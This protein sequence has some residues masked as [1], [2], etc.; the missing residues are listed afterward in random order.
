M[1]Y[2]FLSF[3][4]SLMS[5]LKLSSAGQFIYIVMVFHKRIFYHISA[6]ASTSIINH[7]SFSHKNN[8]C[9]SYL[10]Y[11]S[12]SHKNHTCTSYL[13]HASPS[14]KNHA[15]ISYINHASPPS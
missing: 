2:L 15:S 13:K 5:K 1:K 6:S 3:G 4:T 12:P 10:K 7:A 9:T 8:T 14:H 11:A